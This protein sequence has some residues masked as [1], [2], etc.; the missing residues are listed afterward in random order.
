MMVKTSLSRSFQLSEWW[1]VGRGQVEQRIVTLCPIGLLSGRS[2]G[3]STG[4]RC[5]GVRFII[6]HRPKTYH[7]IGCA[8]QAHAQEHIN[9][10]L[11]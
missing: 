10:A 5:T 4:D 1:R 3:G 8:S 2:L 7:I 9:K 6:N 11:Q